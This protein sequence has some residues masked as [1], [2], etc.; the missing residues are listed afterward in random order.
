MTCEYQTYRAGKLRDCGRPATHRGEK[1]PKRCYCAACNE[2][3]TR[4]GG[5]KTVPL[6]EARP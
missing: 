2:M 5:L 1:P 4:R 6:K 3:V